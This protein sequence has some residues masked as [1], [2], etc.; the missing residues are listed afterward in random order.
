MSEIYKNETV[1]E[2]VVSTAASASETLPTKDNVYQFTQNAYFGT[3]GF[4]NGDYLVAHAK[5]KSLAA[6]KKNIYY[7]NYVKGIVDS[8]V[9]PVFAEDA[10]RSTDSDLFAAFLQNA[11]R[12]GTPIEEVTEYATTLSRLHGVSF[13]VMNNDT[14]AA[15]TKAEALESRSFPYLITKSAADV[16]SFDLNSDGAFTSISFH[17]YNETSSNGVVVGVYRKW[18]S[19]YSVLVTFENGA[20][21]EMPTTK[22]NHEFGILPVVALYSKVS[23]DVM[24]QPPLYDIARMNYGVFNKDSEQRNIERLCAFPTLAIQSRA[25]EGTV[26]IGADN[27]LI[28]GGDYDGSVSAPTWISPASDILRVMND[29]S[30]DLLQKL[31][32]AANVLG[33]SAVNKGNSSKSGVAHSYEFIGQNFAIKKT[34]KVAERFE[35]MVALMFTAIT[36]EITN[37]VVRYPQNYRPTQ[38]EFDRKVSTIERILDLNLSP[39]INATFAAEL[40][41]MS[42]NHYRVETDVEKLVSTIADNSIL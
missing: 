21:V 38:D 13:A 12:K 33:A 15:D 36:G 22:E 25:N 40:V 28:Y 37:Y 20:V 29:M 32:E 30:G 39:Q 24:P 26:E 27:L 34:A 11:D 6:R 2:T 17:E 42:A 19:E 41:K 7:K 23:R 5:E 35:Q 31:I 9:V 10:A 4:Q 8:L 3:G 16:G 14:D 1:S 18:T